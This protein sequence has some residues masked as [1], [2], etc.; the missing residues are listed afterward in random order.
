[1]D[2]IDD[3][4][5]CHQEFVKFLRD[6]D[7]S[8]GLPS[9]PGN[10]PIP[11]PVVEAPWASVTVS[12]EHV[13]ALPAPMLLVNAM[14]MPQ[15]SRVLDKP[16]HPVQGIHPPPR[17]PPPVA[18]LSTLWNSSRIQIGCPPHLPL[19][20]VPMMSTHVARPCQQP[21]WKTNSGKGKQI[22]CKIPSGSKYEEDELESEEETEDWVIKEEPLVDHPGIQAYT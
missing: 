22:Y 13:A 18:G 21:P 3:P 20:A 12:P 2:L 6:L 1:M 4:V 16:T 9:A 14:T 8:N 15:E 17:M 19:N 7:Q 5:G 10:N 11:A